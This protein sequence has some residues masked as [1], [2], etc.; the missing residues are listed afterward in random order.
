MPIG[1]VLY[2]GFET[3][4]SMFLGLSPN[5][6]SNLLNECFSNVLTPSGVQE[7]FKTSFLD[8]RMFEEYDRWSKSYRQFN[9]GDA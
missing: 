5:P 6:A 9:P 3:H 8:K 2:M 7:L 1:D 4:F